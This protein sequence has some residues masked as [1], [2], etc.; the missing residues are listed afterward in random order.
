MTWSSLLQVPLILF[1]SG[2][3]IDAQEIKSSRT[4]YEIGEDITIDFH[5]CDDASN[6]DWI[7][8]YPSGS[9]DPSEEP[10]VWV[11]CFVW[12]AK[13]VVCAQASHL[14]LR[15]VLSLQHWTCGDQNCNVPRVNG[16]VT[17]SFNDSNLEQWPTARGSF[18][19]VLAHNDCFDDYRFIAKSD[20]FYL[21]ESIQECDHIYDDDFS[22]GTSSS[23]SQAWTPKTSSQS[24]L[25]KNFNMGQLI[26]SAKNDI[27]ALIRKEPDLKRSYLRMVFHDCIGGLCDGC[28]NT[29]NMDN[30][31]FEEPMASL[32]ELEEKYAGIL[33]RADLWALASFV[34]VEQA[35]PSDGEGD[36]ISMP[37]RYY[38]R[39]ICD[40]HF[41]MG[42]NHEVCSANLGTDELLEFFAKE[43]DFDARETAAIMGAHTM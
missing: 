28:I 2:G 11:G 41:T 20:R 22:I 19:A 29:L 26:A 18:R 25:K 31:G 7:G 33:S 34:A 9:I 35:M 38:G 42:P 36:S 1:L 4:C 6:N 43:F 3:S 8:L 17:F 12:A 15:L 10:I 13:N 16:T 39:E 32:Q 14:F 24:N 40:D 27:I 5:S 23:N 30:A 37:F 21:V